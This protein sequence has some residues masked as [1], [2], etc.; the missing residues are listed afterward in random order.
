MSRSRGFTLVEL[1]VSIAILALLTTIALPALSNLFDVRGVAA[2]GCVRSD[3]EFLR[4]LAL[5]SGRPHR[6]LFDL[7]GNRYRLEQWTGDQWTAQPDPLTRRPA[8]T[9]FDAE[10]HLQGIQL[11]TATFG[12]GTVVS[13]DA[14]GTPSAAGTAVLVSGGRQYRVEVSSWGLVNV[15]LPED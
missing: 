7:P 12:N 2:A 5:A 11:T 3:L 9:R 4:G 13:F 15:V 14:D 6:A 8:E 1:L 10:P